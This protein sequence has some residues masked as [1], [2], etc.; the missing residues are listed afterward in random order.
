VSGGT[1]A[2]LALLAA[3]ASLATQAPINAA[4]SRSVG[5]AA[6]AACISFLVGF[7]VLLGVCTVRGVGPAAGSLTAT[8]AWAWIGGSFGAAYILAL[9]WSVPQVGA[10]TA[11]AATILSQ[12]V[13]ALLLDR[14]GAFGLPLQAITWTRALGVVLV[15]GGLL[16]TRV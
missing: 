9:T 5:D 2:L 4:L 7:L 13:A 11:A 12:L 1:L 16:L 8:P 3:G 6:V 15:L 14:F 10:L